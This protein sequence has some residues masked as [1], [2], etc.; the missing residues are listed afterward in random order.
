MALSLRPSLTNDFAQ[1]ITCGLQSTL[2][3]SQG[4]KSSPRRLNFRKKCSVSLNSAGLP[5]NLLVGFRSSSGSSVAL[6]LSHWSPRASVYSH[7]GHLPSTYLSGKNLLSRGSNA[8]RVFCLSM[9]P[10]SSS[11]KKILWTT[12]LWFSV[13]VVV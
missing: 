13:I 1:L 10:F 4:C 5:D 2:V 11:F 8:C 6:Q 12:S 9:Y 7:F 3:S